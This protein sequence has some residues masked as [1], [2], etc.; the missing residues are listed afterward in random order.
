MISR[1]LAETF[2][3]KSFNSFLDFQTFG[4]ETTSCETKGGKTKKKK[5]LKD[6]DPLL[7]MTFQFEE[8][9]IIFRFNLKS[10]IGG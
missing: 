7:E 4:N 5:T 3:F 1:F 10:F 8:K 6:F 2:L 9:K